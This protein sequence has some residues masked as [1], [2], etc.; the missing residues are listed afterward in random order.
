MAMQT[1][2][3]SSK[4]LLVM[5]AGFGG[6]ILLKNGKLAE[7][8]REIE[9]IIKGVP[10]A[11]SKHDIPDLATVMRHL[12]QEVRDLKSSRPVTIFNGESSSGNLASYVMP[13]A[14]VGAVGYCYMWWKGWSFSDVMFVTKRNMANA[15]AAMSKQLDTINGALAATK[16]HLTQRIEN[17]DGKV[18]EQKELSKLILGDLNGVKGD[19]SQ[20][21]CDIDSLQN[22]LLGMEEKMA[23]MGGK[24]DMTNAMMLYLCQMAGGV[25]SGLNIKFFQEANA[26][27]QASHPSL[28]I[29]DDNSL[30]GLQF[31]AESLKPKEPE[32]LKTDIVEKKDLDEKPV[33]RRSFRSG[34]SIRKEGI[35]L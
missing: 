11:A 5:G 35:A 30:K 27:L 8:I 14:A 22:M 18:D 17:L 31:L 26:K 7:I 23:L 2:I 10:D 1:G 32:E 4:I 21:G 33:V 24:Q 15:I 13:A 9:D 20:I 25:K 3:A 19:I 34:I 12:A 16:R 28:A 6:S 29:L